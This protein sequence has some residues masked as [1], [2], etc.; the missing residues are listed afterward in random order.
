MLLRVNP[1]HAPWST[2]F[3]VCRL[4][5]FL[6]VFDFAEYSWRTNS[7]GVPYSTND[8]IITMTDSTQLVDQYLLQSSLKPDISVKVSRGKSVATVNDGQ[9]SYNSG[10]ITY[11]C[12]SA[13]NGSQGYA[14]LKDAYIVMPYTVSMKNTGANATGVA[15][16]YALGMKCNIASIVDE[17]KVYLNGK[18]IITPSE[19]KQMWSNVRAIAELTTAEVEKHGADMHLFPDDW[20]SEN[21]STSANAYGDGYSNNNLYGSHSISLNQTTLEH[22]K[23]NTGFVRRV[24]NNPPEVASAT[25]NSH[26]WPTLNKTTSQAIAQMRG[27]GVFKAGADGNVGSTI[28]EWFY[29]LKIRLVDLHP[30]FNEIDLVGNPQLK[31]ELKVQTG[32]SDIAVVGA[33][34][35]TARAMSLIS[36]TLVAGSICPVMVGSANFVSSTQADHMYSVIGTN[37]SGSTIRVAWGAIHNTITT[38]ATAGSYYPFTQSRLLLPFYDIA[39][40]T[41]LVSKPM[42][43]INAP[44]TCQPGSSI[45]DFQVQVGNQNVF[46]DVHSYDWMTFYDEFSKIGAVNGDLSREISNGL[47]G[48]DKWQTAQRILVADC[49]RISEVDVPQSIKVSGTNEATQGTNLLVLVVYERALELDRI[50]GEVYRAD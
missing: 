35:G 30:I 32:Y 31:L 42:K 23:P 26:G 11:D 20:E 5:S 50:T 21:F 8:R 27:T 38:I 1:E 44:W 45:R 25:T 2:V 17:V 43:T 14:S 16:R 9:N 29:M 6:V 40:P 37:I 13:L 41:A 12:Q 19:Y 22:S 18:S 33:A 49:S 39:N 7:H 24:L 15:N 10:I 48:I 47:I 36:T 3:A 4:V 34:A 28:G 46:Q